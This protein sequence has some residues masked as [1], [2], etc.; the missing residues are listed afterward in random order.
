LLQTIKVDSTATSYT[1]Y[2]VTVYT[3]YTI[4]MYAVVLSHTGTEVR[5]TATP[6][7]CTTYE[8]GILIITIYD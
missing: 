8:E 3:E 1:T 2:D 4:L 5:S 7:K 6:Q